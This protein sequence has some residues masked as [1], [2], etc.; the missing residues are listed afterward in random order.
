[1]GCTVHLIIV[2]F[3]KWD[4]YKGVCIYIYNCILQWTINKTTSMTICLQQYKYKILILQTNTFLKLE[5][6]TIDMKNAAHTHVVHL[7]D[8][9][10]LSL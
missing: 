7:W 1:M 9:N 3:T 2:F 5:Q 6:Q 4:L 10:S 8:V